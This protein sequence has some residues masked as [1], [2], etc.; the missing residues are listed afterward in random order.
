[1][2]NELIMLENERIRNVLI[3]SDGGRLLSFVDKRSGR[4]YIWTN[5]RTESILRY[6][7]ANYD[8]LSAGGVEEAFPTGLADELIGDKLP[9]FGELW[10]VPWLVRKQTK[11]F[12][13]M[14]R[15]SSIYPILV[16]KT[17]SLED[18]TLYCSYSL[19][20]EGPTEIPYLF[21]VHPSLQIASGDVLRLPEQ[22]Y[23]VG[24]A[25]N[26]PD[27]LNKTFRWPLLNER[28]LSVIEADGTS[29]ECLEFRSNSVSEGCIGLSDGN[30]EFRVGFDAAFFPAL[31]VWLIYG[32]WRGH[33]C[34]MTE[35]FSGWPFTLSEA[36]THGAYT[37]IKPGELIDTSVT[38]RLM[39]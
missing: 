5:K 34:V 19:E 38:Y 1:M 26:V 24:T 10:S 9:F 14:E 7:G 23:R 12:V 32:G 2:T 13:E 22:E 21:G 17:Y 25:V 30:T 29:G 18:R 37:K 4:D 36:V 35:F 20:N 6:Y 3:P 27:A 33:Y 39:A 15:Y 28:A 11:T 8:D 31:S 16:T